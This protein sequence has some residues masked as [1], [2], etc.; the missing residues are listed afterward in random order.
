MVFAYLHHWCLDRAGMDA[1]EALRACLKTW[2]AGAR[3]KIHFSWPRTET[4]TVERRSRET[5]K[6]ERAQAPPVYTGHADYANP[7]EFITF[8]RGAADLPEFD[9][10]A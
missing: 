2:Q 4:R 7:F 8:L 1:H 6:V 9:R 5:G 10:D 3:P